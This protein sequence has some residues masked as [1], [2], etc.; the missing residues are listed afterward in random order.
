MDNTIRRMVP[1][2]SS[3]RGTAEIS[4]GLILAP[5]LNILSFVRCYLVPKIEKILKFHILFLFLRISLVQIRNVT[6]YE[7]PTPRQFGVVIKYVAS[8]FFSRKKKQN[9]EQFELD[10]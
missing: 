1:V 3:W 5:D 7:L 10:L 8:L 9:D 6:K 2:G 4:F